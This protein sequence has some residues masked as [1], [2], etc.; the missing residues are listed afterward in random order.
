MSRLIITRGLPGSGKTT[1]A[2]AWVDENP[3]HRARVNRD[4]LRAMAHNSVYL[5]RETED[6]ICAVVNAAIAALLRHGVDV[7]NDDTNRN[8][9]TVEVLRQIAADAG[10]EFEVWDL[11]DVPIEACI[12][13]DA[14]R[15]DRT[16]GREV[17]ETMWQ[18]WFAP[19]AR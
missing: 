11:T 14:A 17:I 7:I 13:R 19:A 3:G 15:P 1:K 2:R 12:A 10:A 16:V 18:R 6:Q 8:P 4:D 5:G 9:A